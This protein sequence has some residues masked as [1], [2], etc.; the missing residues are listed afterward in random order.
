MSKGTCY[1]MCDWRYRLVD[2]IDYLIHKVIGNRE[3][4]VLCNLER[5]MYWRRFDT[6]RPVIGAERIDQ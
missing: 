2:Q 6:Q 1:G 4:P 5:R 3:M